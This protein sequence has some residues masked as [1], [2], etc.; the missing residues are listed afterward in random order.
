MLGYHYTHATAHYQRAIELDPMDW[1]ALEGLARCA[2]EQGDHVSAIAWQEKAIDALPENLHWISGF[3]WPRISDWAGQL[4]DAEMAFRSAV[5]GFRANVRCTLAET[6]YVALLDQRGC[7][8]EL[9]ECLKTLAA[10]DVPGA[11]YNAL[12][13]L[14]VRNE[15]VFEAIGRACAKEGRPEF[16]LDA[17][18]EAAE[19]VDTGDREEVKILLPYKAGRFKYKF[20][21]LEQQATTLLESFLK[22]LAQKNENLQSLHAASRRDARNILAQFYFDAAVAEWKADH[23]SRPASADKLK[24]LAVGVSTGFGDDYEG[25]DLFRTDYPAMLWGRWLRD[26]KGA[27]DAKWRKCF[28][29]RLLEEMNTVDDDDPTNDTIGISSLAI[30]LFHAGDRANAAAIMAILFRTTS[31]PQTDTNPGAVENGLKLNISQTESHTC[32]NCSRGVEDVTELHICEVCPGRVNWCDQ[33]LALLK[34]PEGRKT[35]LHQCNPNH[36]F[37]RAW[38]IP[39]EALHVAAQSFENGVTVREEWLE[40]LRRQWWG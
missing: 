34:A 4:G 19:I 12:V 33:C 27:E 11:T 21:G 9:V 28:R 17:L 18:N 35:T 20:Y 3:L 38:P 31:S 7:S 30:S 24:Q 25:F 22:R 13:R 6:T 23:T 14:F 5:E 32:N 16:V 29:A 26:C 2:G 40:E 8:V 36:D 15:D 1:V 37:Y 39:T 10:T